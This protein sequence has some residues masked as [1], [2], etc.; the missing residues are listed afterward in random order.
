MST[1]EQAEQDIVDMIDRSSR[2]AEIVDAN[3]GVQREVDVQ[4]LF[5]AQDAMRGIHLSRYRKSP[6]LQEAIRRAR[7]ALAEVWDEMRALR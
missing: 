3:G 1:R 2:M 4:E 5:T 6:E 7:R